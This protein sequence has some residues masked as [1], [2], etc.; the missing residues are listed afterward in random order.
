MPTYEYRCSRGHEFELF[1]RMSD[2]PRADCPTCGDQAERLLSAGAG[3]LFKGEGFYITDYRSDAY[4]AAA[5]KESGGSSEKAASPAGGDGSKP[6]AP[7][8]SSAPAA[9]PTPPSAGK[10]GGG[11]T[12]SSSSTASAS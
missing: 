11:T 3:F 10:G 5:R 2:E 7:A 8:A 4:R 1:Q 12:G 6:A 9:A